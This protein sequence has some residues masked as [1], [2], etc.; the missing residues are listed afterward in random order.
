MN[1]IQKFK[2]EVDKVLSDI[3]VLI[4]TLNTGSP[5]EIDDTVAKMVDLYEDSADNLKKALTELKGSM[6]S[7]RI[8]DLKD[9][10]K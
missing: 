1:D 5:V 2:N 9:Y 7:V 6:G 10:G 3:D 8:V 4:W